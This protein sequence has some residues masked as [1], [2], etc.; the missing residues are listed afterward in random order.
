MKTIVAI[1]DGIGA[2]VGFAIFLV[3]W[4]YCIATFGFLIGVGFGWFPS[5]IVGLIAYKLW[6]LLA[7]LIFLIVI[8]I[9]KH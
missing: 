4:I 7:L 3:C 9:N 1:F 5:A 2:L 6:P 8:Q